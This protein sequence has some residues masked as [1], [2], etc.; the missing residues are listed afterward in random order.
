MRRGGNSDR[1]KKLGGEVEEK[2]EGEQDINIEDNTSVQFSL[3]LSST[4]QAQD[5]IF[6]SSSCFY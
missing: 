1:K 3:V 6:I 4:K 2:G 5:R